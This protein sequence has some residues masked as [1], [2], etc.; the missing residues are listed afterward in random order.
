MK[1]DYNALIQQAKA[2]MDSSN[3]NRNVGTQY[4][5]VYPHVDGKLT[6]R[7]LFNNKAQCVQRQVIRHETESKEK[8]PCLQAY[9]TDCPACNAVKEISDLLGKDSGVFKKYGYKARGICYAVIVDHDNTYFTKPNDPKKG[10]VILFMYPKTV[11]EK[12][13]KIV[14]EAGENLESVIA[15]NDGIPV[16]VTRSTGTNGFPQY[17][18]AVFPYGTRRCFED[19]ENGLGQDKFDNLLEN[20]PNISEMVMPAQPT[21]EVLDKNRALADL[22][23]QKYVSSTVV[24]PVGAN[25][26]SMA[27]AG[28]NPTANNGQPI[29]TNPTA[30][31]GKPSCY[32]QFDNSAKCS[33]CI[34]ES[35]CYSNS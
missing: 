31:T 15:K 35:D 29:S 21:E 6:L 28:I 22:I 12:I 33:D 13:N 23:R 5:I 2:E 11:Y 17:D 19:D 10:D 27:Q 25:P 34:F 16:I 9:G 14:F 20:L 30:N 4:P 26:A 18:V 1:F 7:I 32:G 24:N 8:I 3:G